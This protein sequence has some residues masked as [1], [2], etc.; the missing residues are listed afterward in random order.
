MVKNHPADRNPGGQVPAAE[1]DSAVSVTNKVGSYSVN[2][3][4]VDIVLYDTPGFY[5]PDQTNGLPTFAEIRVETGGG[6][7]LLLIC[8]RMGSRLDSG[9]ICIMQQITKNMG[10][11][12]WKKAAYV[13][14]FANEVKPPRRRGATPLTEAETIENYFADK[15]EKLEE[16]LH[17]YLQEEG[18]VSAD[19]AQKVPV[20]PA[21]YDDPALP[22]CSN[23][24]GVL[25]LTLCERIN[26]AS[27]PA[28]LKATCIPDVEPRQED[29]PTTTPQ[30]DQLILATGAGMKEAMHTFL[31]LGNS[32]V[33]RGVVMRVP[34]IKA[35]F[36]EWIKTFKHEKVE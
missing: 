12:V 30:L 31:R 22:G 1:G 35:K 29:L 28:L 36:F 33:L 5:G 17:E 27:Q 24:Y 8:K 6:I 19:I 32:A 34:A 7:D 18:H 2:K 21:G 20:V 23:W 11:S 4:D 13:L 16:T 15:L 3:N 25:W 14:T 26:A 9:D 10:E